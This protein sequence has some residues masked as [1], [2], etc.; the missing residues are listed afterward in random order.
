MQVRGYSHARCR[1]R[2]KS[3]A[4]RSPGD[5]NH[6]SPGAPTAQTKTVPG[7]GRYSKPRFNP[8]GGLQSRFEGGQTTHNQKVGTCRARRDRRVPPSPSAVRLSA[9]RNTARAIG[10]ETWRAASVRLKARVSPGRIVCVRFF[11]TPQPIDPFRSCQIQVPENNIKYNNNK[12]QKTKFEKRQTK[13]DKRKKK[14]KMSSRL[15]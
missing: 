10:T 3:H 8:F 13:N 5:H 2:L 12:I 4:R 1:Q 9:L 14:K 6:P 15:D 11:C 7:V